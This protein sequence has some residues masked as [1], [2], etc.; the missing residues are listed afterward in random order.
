MIAI[1]F[2][3]QA[4]EVPPPIRTKNTMGSLDEDITI[5]TGLRVGCQHL[6]RAPQMGRVDKESGPEPIE[7]IHELDPESSRMF[8]SSQP[9]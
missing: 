4:A 7:H 5:F 1:H 9:Q 2:K 8:K 6:H 3:R